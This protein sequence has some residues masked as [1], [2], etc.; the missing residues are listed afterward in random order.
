MSLA[1]SSVTSE[2]ESSEANLSEHDCAKRPNCFTHCYC[3]QIRNM[4]ESSIHYLDTSVQIR[5]N[6]LR[7]GAPPV[8][9]WV[10]FVDPPDYL[11]S[12]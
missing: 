9:C 7:T 1:Q 8:L 11:C 12:V 4:F 3:R 10:A 2:P 6:S 5:E